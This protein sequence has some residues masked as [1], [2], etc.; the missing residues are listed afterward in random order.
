MT[1][2]CRGGDRELESRE[3]REVIIRPSSRPHGE[4]YGP[5]CERCAEEA[6]TRL[7]RPVLATTTARIEGS[8]T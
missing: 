8:A 4:V 5:L 6:S 7:A 1:A 3:V 2:P